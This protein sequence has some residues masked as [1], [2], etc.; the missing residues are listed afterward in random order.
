MGFFADG[1]GKPDERSCERKQLASVEKAAY[2]VITG[3]AGI[4][5]QENAV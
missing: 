3:D 1:P 4:Y 2:T 5:A